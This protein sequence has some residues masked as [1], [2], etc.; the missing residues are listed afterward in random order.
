MVRWKK[1]AALF[2]SSL[3]PDDPHPGRE[4][5]KAL[6]V[7]ENSQQHPRVQRSD[8]ESCPEEEPKAA[9]GMTEGWPALQPL[10]TG[11]P[12]PPPGLTVAVGASE[13]PPFPLRVAWALGQ[14]NAQKQERPSHPAA[15]ADPALARAPQTAATP[16]SI[17]PGACKKV[18]PSSSCAKGVEE[19]SWAS[20]Q[21][22]VRPARLEPLGDQWHKLNPS[23][24][25]YGRK[26]G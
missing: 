10:C 25:H 13:G 7:K 22:G 20:C 9:P 19:N 12:R 6:P 18:K 15:K 26:G 8:G 5:Q 2:P 17:Q 21:T 3:T 23:C 4:G 16:G 11:D 24:L 1:K 14:D